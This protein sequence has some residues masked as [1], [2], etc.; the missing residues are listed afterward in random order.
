[1][2]AST[3]PTAH[4]ALPLVLGAVVSAA[5][6]VAVV[7]LIHGPTTPTDIGGF[8]QPATTA[9]VEVRAQHTPEAAGTGLGV[10]PPPTVVPPGS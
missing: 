10:L 8:V 9:P 1:M 7:G 3:G 2:R 4:W 5:V 6:A